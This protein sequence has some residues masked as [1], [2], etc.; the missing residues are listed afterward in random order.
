MCSRRSRQ[1]STPRRSVRRLLIALGAVAAAS[2]GHAQT[3]D[4]VAPILATR[5]A[6]CHSGANAAAG[7]ALDSLAGLLQ[8]GRNGAVVVPGAPGKSELMRRL[9][10]EKQPRMPMTGPPFLSDDEIQRFE[11]WIAGGLKAGSGGEKPAPQPPR[12]A[13][14]VPVTYA[15]VA[16]IFAT[17]CAKCHTEQGLMGPA[18][19]GYRLTSH[20]ATVAVRDRAR[21]VPG[22]PA[23]SELLRRLRGQARPRMPLD[24]P[25]YLGDEDIALIERWIADGARD[26]SG[27]PTPPAVGATVRLHGRLMAD[28][29]LDGLRFDASTARL[30]KSPQP[31]DYVELRGVVGADGRIHAERLR[32]R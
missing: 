6:M 9:T 17:R 1:N 23:A 18:P 2:V 5:C 12:P 14:G 32:V 16:P 10:G 28:G 25:P 19:E 21:V 8:G 13:A 15:H 26:A 30:R 3:Y 22:Q 29:S 20:A 11:R 24:G 31:G 4:D 27:T 7:L